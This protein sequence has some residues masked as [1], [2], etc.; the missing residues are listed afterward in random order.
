MTSDNVENDA[1]TTET[2]GALFDLAPTP[3]GIGPV[4]NAAERTLAA[5]RAADLIG[6]EH[7][8]T[9][10]MIRQMASAVDR[11]LSAA[12]VSIATTTLARELRE[13]LA[14]LPTGDVQADESWNEIVAGLRDELD[15]GAGGG[16]S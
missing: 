16:A 14:T 7:T 5:K 9:V 12:K 1:T 11:G 8:L 6:D 3:Q 2:S 15:A 4:R 10:E 13:L